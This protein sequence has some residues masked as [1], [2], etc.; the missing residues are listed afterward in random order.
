MSGRVLFQK[1][2][3]GRTV[4]LTLT[5]TLFSTGIAIFGFVGWQWYVE[6]QV[7]SVKQIEQVREVKLSVIPENVE[8][9]FIPDGTVFARMFIPSWGESWVRPVVEGTTNEALWS[10]IGHYSNSSYPGAVGNFAVASHR[11]VSGAA[12]RDI[13]KLVN[14][15]RIFV[16]TG[17]G[18]YEYAVLNSRIVKPTDVGVLNSVP[19][20][21]EATEGISKFITLTTCDPI[22]GNWNRY[23]VFGGLVNFYSEDKAPEVVQSMLKAIGSK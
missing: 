1:A 14:G 20:G 8:S 18:F 4:F 2:G 21:V 3:L 11:T 7:E 10:G 5:L 13:D 22:Y 15:D 12:F 9:D 6:P 23:V 16:E 17:D 19:E